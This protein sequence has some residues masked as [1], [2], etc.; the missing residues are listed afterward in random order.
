MVGF[1]VGLGETGGELAAGDVDGAGQEDE[2]G[3]LLE[4]GADIDEPVQIE[5]LATE[6]DAVD[7]E[8][9]FDADDIGNLLDL[10]NILQPADRFLGGEEVIQIGSGEFEFGR[11]FG[12]NGGR[13]GLQ[14]ELERRFLFTGRGRGSD[15]L[16]G[17]I[18]EATQFH[19]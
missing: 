18:G 2:P 11:L 15:H 16:G 7:G 9:D 8:G 17:G 3:I 14:P 5:P 10:G 13:K 4:F 19:H 6:G 1:Q 12:V